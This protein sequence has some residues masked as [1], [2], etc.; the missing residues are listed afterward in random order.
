MNNITFELVL[1]HKTHTCYCWRLRLLSPTHRHIQNPLLLK[2]DRGAIFFQAT[3]FYAI[4]LASHKGVKDERTVCQYQLPHYST[5]PEYNSIY[6]L[7]ACFT[8]N[9][10]RTNLNVQLELTSLSGPFCS[11]I[12][13]FSFRGTDS[14]FNIL[15]G[16]NRAPLLW[17]SR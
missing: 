7:P 6:I 12:I 5:Y 4:W 17:L 8:W 9:L 14:P 16:S 11:G 15:G 2:Q 3:A 1:C 13:F 10:I